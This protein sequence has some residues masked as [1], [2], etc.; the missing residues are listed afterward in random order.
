MADRCQGHGFENR[1]H[2][3][4]SDVALGVRKICLA[5]H[6]LSLIDSH[7]SVID[8]KGEQKC[9]AHLESFLWSARTAV[10]AAKRLSHSPGTGGKSVRFRGQK[11]R[12][13]VRLDGNG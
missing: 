6:N 3:E 4:Q 9:L 5:T 1:I 8:V 13:R 12:R 7:L 2:M 10:S 11:L